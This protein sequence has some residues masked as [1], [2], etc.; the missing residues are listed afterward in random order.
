MDNSMSTFI[1]K[2]TK[3]NL[4]VYFEYKCELR[5]KGETSKHKEIRNMYDDFSRELEVNIPFD[6][7][8]A[9]LEY[10]IMKRYFEEEP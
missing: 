5:E 4:R 3:E 8:R 1:E 7:F 9:I 10:E 2:L 6:A